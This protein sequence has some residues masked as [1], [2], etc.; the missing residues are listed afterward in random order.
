MNSVDHDDSSWFYI[1][2]QVVSFCL[3]CCVH[4]PSRL[5]Q[6]TRHANTII[7][8]RVPISSYAGGSWMAVCERSSKMRLRSASAGIVQGQTQGP[9]SIRQFREWLRH[10]RRDPN[11][12]EELK[13]FSDVSVWRVRSPRTSPLPLSAETQD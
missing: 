6:Q 3:L 2:P 4:L 9:C 7:E 11:L 5:S 1:D 8:K 10:M 12:Y 13:Q